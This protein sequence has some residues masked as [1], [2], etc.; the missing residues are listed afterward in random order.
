MANPTITNINVR[1]LVMEGASYRDETFT[2]AG[3]AT[4]AEGTILA[5][6]AVATAV[7]VA[8]GSNTG[9]GTCTVASVVNSP[10]VPIVGAYVLTCI[11]AVTHGGIFKLVDPN[12]AVV[13]NYLPMTASTGAATV[14]EVGGLVFT[15]TDGSTD[16]AAADS[17][18]ITVAAN[19]KLVV[20][21]TAG[22]GGAQIPVAVLPYEVITSGAGDV[23]IRALVAGKVIKEELVINGGG[24]VTNA[25]L[26]QLRNV[27]IV[28]ANVTELNIQDNQ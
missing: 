21:A 15:L 18:T 23:S 2:A 13:S 22:A 26:D 27:G 5:R 25:I 28:A 9:N 11:T 19:G 8:A 10:I 16:F 7:V 24:T 12:G 14:F 20:Y 4:Y 3:A 1:N 6:Q 17:F